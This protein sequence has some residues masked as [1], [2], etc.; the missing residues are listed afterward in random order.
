[1]SQNKYTPDYT[2]MW[3]WDNYAQEIRI[4]LRQTLDEGKDVEKYRDLVEAVSK[5]ENNWEK[6]RIA[7]QIFSLFQKAPMREGY[8]YQE[9]DELEAIRALCK[10]IELPQRDIPDDETLRK[11]MEGAWLGRICGCL[12]GKPLEGIRT[13]ELHALLKK[14]G[15]WPMHRYMLSTDLTEEN[16]KGNR[17]TVHRNTCGDTVTRG[18]VDDDTNYTALA[19]F[20]IEEHGRNFTPS[21][22]A[23]VWQTQQ[24]RSAYCTAE[25]VAYLNFTRGYQPPLSGS[26]QNVFRE[27]IGAQIR[28]D[29]FGYICPGDPHTAAEYGWR[30]ACISHV[31]NGIYGEMYIAAMNARAAVESSADAIEDIIRCGMAEIPATSRLYES[32]QHVLDLY[33]QGVSADDCFA[34]IHATWNEAD[35][36]D[37]CHTISNAMIVTAALLYGGGDFGKSMCMAVQACFD[38]DCNGATVG[39]IVGMLVGSDAIGEEWTGPVNGC[40]ETSLLPVGVLHV[41]KAVEMTMKHIKA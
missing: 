37:W 19:Q 20:L 26:Y 2:S 3:W 32:I 24:P 1:M 40:V 4:E 41:D 14:T 28:G 38:T 6:N 17:F 21:D 15:N 9:P 13:D 35:G 11:K 34:D 31:K 39:S 18:P 25:R 12:L 23:G 22:V 33:H 16:V 29:Y 30:D 10:P 8:P 27:Y 5:L 36:Y 7:D